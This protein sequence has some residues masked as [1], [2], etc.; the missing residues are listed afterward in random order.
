MSQNSMKDSNGNITSGAHNSFWIDSIEQKRYETLQ[1][2][3]ETDVLVIGGGI[4]G[5]TTAYCLV[6]AGRKVVL[7]EDGFL[8][9]GETGRTTAHV[10]NALDDGYTDLIRM[11]GK[12][13]A[14]LAAESHTAAISFVEMAVKELE[15][16]CD[17]TRL[18]G[19][20]FLHPTDKEK[21]L[22]DEYNATHE[23]G[24]NTIMLDYIPGIDF[25]KGRSLQF[26]NQAQFHPLKYLTALTGFIT[27]NGGTIYTETHAEKFKKDA[28]TANG[29]TIK[30]DHIVVAT[31][32]PINNVFTEH[33]KQHPYR[34]YVIGTLIPKNTLQKALWWDTGDQQSKWMNYPY[35][36]VR[37]Q[38]YNEKHDLL[39]V[40]GED[41]KTGQDDAEKITQEDRYDRLYSWTKR[42]FQAVTDV[43][44]NW[45]GQVLEPVDS[46]AFIGKN[47]GE[48][49]VYIITGDSGNG[50]THGTI[51]GMLIT[52]LITGKDNRWTKIY[53][54]SRISLK[55]TG[56]FLK[57]AG[58]MAAQY[59]DYFKA[60]D[61]KSQKELAP[62]EGAIINIG[63][64]KVAVYKD[65]S[66]TTHAYS[67]IC[68]HLGC[69]VQWN[70]D[71]KSFD[72]PC[73]G[74]RF[75]TEGVVINGPA[76]TN[77]KKFEIKEEK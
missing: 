27:K 4:S 37:T 56:D 41:H 53:D 16:D 7:I 25:Q 47:P 50:M 2:D 55:A 49:N 65:N 19:Y 39:L 29:H 75:S 40:G 26:P 9:S 44:Y 14:T 34:T 67:A 24:L 58:N 36:Y 35:H 3:I 57:E 38:T 6:K 12:E 63:L 21:T 59:A 64:H 1:S 76:L 42:H 20:L 15:I 31:N 17:F 48:D 69:I 5:I 52:D 68:P 71:E 72:C 30:A 54:P 13:N 18:D 73:H 70:D 46:L 43:V 61:L 33:T 45:S 32:S 10:V 22:D 51:G 23:V 74:S 11:H 62:N 77:L 28:V 8:F 66:S 60:G